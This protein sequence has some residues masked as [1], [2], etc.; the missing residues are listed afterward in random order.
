MHQRWLKPALGIAVW[1]AALFSPPDAHAQAVGTIRGRVVEASS[2]EGVADAQLSIVGTGSGALTNARGEFVI[3]NVAAGARV[4]RVRRIG[5]T[6]LERNITV[7][8]GQETRV[9]LELSQSATQLSDFVVTGTAGAAERRT[10]GNSITQLNVAEATEKSNIISVSEVLQ[11]KTPGVTLLPGSGAPGTAG[12]FRIR[13]TGSISGYRPVVFID[14]VRYN[15]DALATFSATGAG[16]TGLAQSSQVTSAL[17]FLNPDDIESI[18]VVKGPAAATLYGADAANG[19]IQIITKKG[20]RGQQQ[21]RWN[22]R[23]ERGQ[24]EWFLR[25]DDNYTTCDA[26]KQAA[27]ET[28]GSPTWP[29]CQSLPVNSVITDNPLMSDPEAL[30]EGNI[31]RLGLNVRG[32]G[33]RY[34]FFLSGD[35]DIEQGV[36]FNSDNARTSVRTNFSFNPNEKADFALNVNWQDTRLRLPMQDESAAGLLLSS[37]RGRPGRVSALDSRL[38]EGWRTIL[39]A[40]SNGYKNF[41]DGERL[42]LSGTVNYNPFGWLRNR[43]V[44]GLDNTTSQAQLLFLPGDDGEP[45]GANAQRTPITRILTLDYSGSVLKDFFGGNLTTQSTIGSQVVANRTETLAATGTGLGAPD[46]T[47]IGLSQVTSGSNAFSENNSVGYYVQEQVGWKNRL[48]LTAAVRA[49]DNSSFGENFDLIVYP[50]FSLSWV[51]TEEP[52]VQGLLQKAHVNSFKLRS[53]WGQAGRA[54]SPYSATQTYTVGRV[55]TGN[56]IGSSLRTNAY[57]NPDL[58]PEK[59]DEVE[60][61]FDAGMFGERVGIDFTWY[62]KKTSD[63]L[64]SVAL[65]PSLG[66]P[67]SRLTNLGE[68]INRGVELSITGTP[69]Q[70][71]RIAW[72][73]RFIYSSNYN[74]LVSFGIPNTRSQTPTGQAYGAVQQHRPGYP[75][76]GYWAPNPRRNPDGSPVTNAAGAVQLDTAQYLGQPVPAHEFGFSNTVTLF[77]Y[78]RLYALLDWKTGGQIFNLKERNRCQGQDNCA[79]TN[80]GRARFPQ[81]AADTLLNKELAVYRSASVAAYWIQPSDFVKLREVSLTIE[82]PRRYAQL[83]RVASASVLLAGRNLALWSDYQGIDPEVNSYGGRNFVRVDAYASP[84]T[85]RLSAGINL[86]F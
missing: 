60:I 74:E 23:A 80:V 56:Q 51:L 77:R 41:T 67:G 79:L 3:A 18:E 12:E 9:D 61:G 82:I 30:R 21:L 85:R 14:G 22:M 53:A 6:P 48:Y 63:M 66:F 25:P 31:T 64:Q 40:R 50:K 1:L 35:R 4:L 86:T 38:T 52:M 11:S 15:T 39:P 55:V 7:T 84:M 44:L 16:L 5:F 62:N 28:N 42:T 49:D 2:K 73:A 69:V 43:V 29:G 24:S 58:K 45:G 81:T 75:L 47:L 13:G 83:M 78:F 26:L 71:A 70:T 72:D 37:V 76:G 59:G 33:D 20:A 36:F 57:G 27:R 34:S 10:V 68:V 32:G 54:P 65:A 46:V 19:V 17:D 8:V